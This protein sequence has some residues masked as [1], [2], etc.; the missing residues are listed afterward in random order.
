MSR[1][2]VSFEDGA[3]VLGEDAALEKSVSFQEDATIIDQ[4]GDST[5][6]PVDDVAQMMDEL[7]LKKA[8]LLIIY[9]YL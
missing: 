4:N 5:E 2:S 8:S 7:S 1:K 6:A 9:P 3:T